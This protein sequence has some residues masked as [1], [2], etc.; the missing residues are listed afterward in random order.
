MEIPLNE[1]YALL[2][3]KLQRPNNRFPTYVGVFYKKEDRKENVSIRSLLVDDHAWVNK[4]Y[5][6]YIQDYNIW[7]NKIIGEHGTGR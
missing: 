3:G 6:I 5:T 2:Q 7:L 4:I 1:D